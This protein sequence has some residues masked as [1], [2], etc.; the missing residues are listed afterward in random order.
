MSKKD[1]SLYSKLLWSL[2]CLMRYPT[3]RAQEMIQR[4]TQ[5]NQ[6]PHLILIMANH[7]EPSWGNN[8]FGADAA[9]QVKRL[10][11]WN[12]EARLTGRVAQD[13]DGMPFRH[14][15]YFPAEQ[16]V[17]EVLDRLAGL[18]ADGFGEVEIHLH[19]GLE[20][21]DTPENLRRSL[22][23]FRDILAYEHKCLSRFE[24]SDK[25]MYSFV[26][27]NFALAN[28]YDN[29]CGVD[30]ELQI[31]ADTGC[32]LDLTLPAAPAKTQVPMINAF[33]EC[34]RP[35]HERRAHRTGNNL[36]INGKYKLPLILTG[37]L[38]L[39]WDRRLR[40]LP[41]PG[42]DNGD[43][44]HN[45]QASLGRLRSWRNASISVAGRPEWIFI[46][47]SSHGFLPGDMAPTI[48]EPMRRFLGEAMEYAARTG[49][50]KLHYATAREAYNIAMAAVDGHQ[51]S[52]GQYRDY[53]LRQIMDTRRAPAVASAGRR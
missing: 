3:W 14:T 30:S 32:Y 46:K 15:Y 48:G 36:R 8:G 1:E 35:L 18:Q 52:P 22:E 4:A 11:E 25:P 28:T 40:G 24:D 34:G 33:Y 43:L 50:F 21:P 53:R 10:E 26:H 44:T 16:Y 51:G 45:Y 19:H 38:V 49:E 31:L 37:P 9:T 13:C 7:F 47:L 23:E 29:Y 20:K 39:D 2:P 41:L 12:K 42:I 5:P 17:P 6:T 27:G